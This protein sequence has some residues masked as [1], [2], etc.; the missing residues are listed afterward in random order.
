MSKFSVEIYIRD[1]NTS[2]LKTM[3]R[4]PCRGEIIALHKSEDLP[5]TLAENWEYYNVQQ[6][7]TLVAYYG[8][9][10]AVEVTRIHMVT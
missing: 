5:L 9:S 2:I 4:V 6:V 1:T 10:Y 3:R 7:R 8:D